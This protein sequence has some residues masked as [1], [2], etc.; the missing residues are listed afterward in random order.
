M[1]ALLFLVLTLF[2]ILPAPGFSQE[3]QP[4]RVRST[5]HDC[6]HVR[7]DHNTSATIEPCLALGTQVS[8]LASVPYWQH[9]QY[10][11]EQDGWAA[12]KFLEPLPS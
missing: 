7:E 9:I 2:L 11:D 12:K 3:S 8:V 6:L 10:G 1:R 4:Y 5:V